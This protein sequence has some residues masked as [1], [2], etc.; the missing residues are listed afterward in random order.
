[1]SGLETDLDLVGGGAPRTP[2]WVL[3]GPNL[4]R[5]GAREPEVYGRL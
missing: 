5:L 4:G 1:M 3:N 2:V